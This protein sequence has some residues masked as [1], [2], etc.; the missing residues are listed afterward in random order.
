MLSAQP[1]VEPSNEPRKFQYGSPC[2]CVSGGRATSLLWL[3]ACRPAGV[4]AVPLSTS[5][6]SL[7]QS[8]SGRVAKYIQMP[9]EFG[10]PHLDASVT[11]VVGFLFGV[12]SGDRQ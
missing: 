8:S 12:S 7:P 5:P 6:K 4:I 1:V 2:R 9:W 11:F 10:Q 3:G